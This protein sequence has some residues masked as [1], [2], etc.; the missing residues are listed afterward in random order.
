M[1]DFRPH[2]SRSVAFE[3]R[4]LDTLLVE[5]QQAERKVAAAVQLEL[6]D[7]MALLKPRRGGFR[8]GGWT[9]PPLAPMARMKD[10]LS[11]LL[12]RLER[13]KE[14][15]EAPLEDEATMA[16]MNLTLLAQQPKLARSIFINLL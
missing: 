9:L 1:V 11:R 12:G 14:L 4:A 7:L 10:R 5:L 8:T 15:L 13:S 16:L 6:N 3:F 2:Q